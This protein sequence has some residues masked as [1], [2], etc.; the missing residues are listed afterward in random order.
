MVCRLIATTLIIL[1]ATLPASAL[2]LNKPVDEA[3]AT[4]AGRMKLKDFNGARQA[5]LLSNDKGA[6]AFLLGISS[7]R[8]ELWEEGATNLAVAADYYPILADYALY[9][10]GLALSKLGR[11]DEALTPLY[12]MLK[13]YPDSRLARAAVILYADTLAAGGYHKQALESYA[14]FIERY[15]SGSDSISALFGSALCREK[16][17]DPAAA[18]AVLRGIWLNSPAS[19]FAE[20]GADEL[21]RLAAAGTRVEPYT[22]AELFKRGGTLYD[23]GRYK[24]AAEAYAQLPIT[25]ETVEFVAKLR[26]K[27]GQALLKA[28]QYR[29][30]Q[31]I[32]KGVIQ[33]EAGGDGANEAKFWLA[34]ALDKSG[35]G[36]EAYELL[37]RLA[38][39]PNGGSVANDALLEAAY[40]KRY[41]R[42]WDEALQLF[43]RYLANVPE[44]KKSGTVMWEA[45]W[46][47]Y[48]SRDFPGAAA[49]FRKLAE[50]EE[51]REKAL[52]WLGKALIAAGDAKGAELP[53]ATL[54]ADY[55]FGYY[56]LIC[57]R[58]CDVADAPLAPKSLTE[59]LPMPAGF[60][61][62]KA[63][64]SLGLFDEA[65]RE[66]TVV[67]RKNPLGAARLYLEMGNYNGALH[68]A[69]NE[70]PKRGEKESP[71]VWGLKYP[72][73]FREDVV[74]NAS[75]NAVPE[76]LVYAI[77]RTESNYHPTALSPVGA[78][79]LMQIMPATAESIS[80]GDSG[81][82]TRPELNIRLGA[83][84]LRDLMEIYDQNLPLVMAAYNAGS[85]NVK[86]WQKGL[87][88]LP[89]DEFIE[90]IP[91]KETREYVKKVVTAMELYQRLYRVP[92]EK[93]LPGVA[94][95]PP[96]AAPGST[97]PR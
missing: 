79:G 14:S 30:A 4:A 61:R 41:Q 58:W 95:A 82:L 74:K 46:A 17:G 37:I 56:A 21:K 36:E 2:N 81:K 44:Q 12:R 77:M 26:L 55:P 53:L 35:Q 83:R 87:G 91:F 24:K 6:R 18:A 22:S 62:E 29:D 40:L 67:R 85:G 54:A 9:N 42:K 45:A 50:R 90:S 76:S 39:A 70:K 84:H 20:K 10:Q 65:A 38:E 13:Q 28:R 47:G 86:R 60:E 32:F 69:A 5:A 19:P 63:L 27:T 71:A 93:P 7:I 80:K 34:K 94:A 16:L 73:A 51:M 33:M 72:Q 49:D 52:Y 88:S 59:S 66:L 75:S 48:Q 1:S 68:S 64:I 15:P 25:G 11:W 8:L 31:A 23:L 97:D 78:V 43:R 92:A 3:L 89:Q 96:A 57:N